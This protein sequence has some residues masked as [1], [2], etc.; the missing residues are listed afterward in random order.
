MQSH[1]TL[2]QPITHLMRFN[3]FR[4]EDNINIVKYYNPKMRSYEMVYYE[5]IYFR[6]SLDSDENAIRLN[7]SLSLDRTLE[8]YRVSISSAVRF[9][10][11]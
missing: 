6:L 9:V 4:K 2:H 10:V 1:K 5:R 3:Q 7:I 11:A 8:P